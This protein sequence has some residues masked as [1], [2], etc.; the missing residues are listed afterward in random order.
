LPSA[1]R[2]RRTWRTFFFTWEH[3]D[4]DT[5]VTFSPGANF[6]VEDLPPEFQTLANQTT[7]S[8]F[9]ED[10]YFA[11]LDWE[12]NDDNLL[13]LT[14]KYR[15]EDEL[16]A[17]GGTNTAEHGTLK[18]GDETRIDLRWQW[19]QSNWLNDAHLTYEGRE[20]R[21]ARGQH[22]K[23]LRADRPITRTR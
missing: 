23:R 10:L 12:L 20:L 13:E 4:F 5:P 19:T 16:A 11:K 22:R 17:V 6:G 18:K 21:P 2:L 7:S 9:Q 8:P 14:A 1:A 15:T 3:K